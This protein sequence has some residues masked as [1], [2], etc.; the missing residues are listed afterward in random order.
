VSTLKHIKATILKEWLLFG[1][2]IGGLLV[3]L[4]MP[5][6]LIF[7]MALVQDAPFRDYQDLHLEVLL[8]DEDG[9]ALSTAV[10]ETLSTSKAFKI[11]DKLDGR[12]LTADN[13]RDAVRS[14]KHS[15]GL[16]IPKGATAEVVNAANT[17]ANT[18]AE[19][20]GTGTLP[21]RPPR[22]SL[23]V[24]LLF[25]PISRP[26]FRLAIHAALDKA[27][28]GASTKLLVSRISRLS[29]KEADSIEAPDLPKLLAGL[30]IS[31]EKTNNSHQIPKH[32]NS[33]QHNVPAWAIFGMFFIVVP[34]SGHIIRE[35]E[36]GSALRVR[37]IPGAT[38]G[39]AIGRILA[40]TSICCMQFILMC[41][42]GRWLLPL[43]GLT[44]LSLGT[45]PL[46]LIPIVVA[47]GLCATAFGNLVGTFFRTY[48][49]ALPFGAISIVILSALG[50]IW[51]PVELLPPVLQTLAKISPLH[52]A[53]DGVQ[54][55]I[56][57][58]GGW[59]EAIIPTAVLSTIAAAFFGLSILREQLK[60]RGI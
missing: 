14:G 4:V 31:E 21:Q 55:V 16:I 42:V 2:D 29:G 28:S 32:I 46:A 12:A 44:S 5:A 40:N 50:G 9:G 48:G 3:L 47:T 20:L 30:S 33:V 11:V 22:D 15:I 36:E 57:R 39:V 24:R 27:I 13:I 53:L 35:R 19:K 17:I 26:A 1:R 10:R 58:D 6:I 8:A 23:H 49:Q 18:L 41:A 59:K 52:W 25:D 51:V 45:H 7:I 43:A 56:L 54:T 38:L 60:E 34:L 37:L